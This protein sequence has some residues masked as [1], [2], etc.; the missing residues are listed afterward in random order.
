[1]NISFYNGDVN[2][3]Y[4]YINSSTISVINNHNYIDYTNKGDYFSINIYLRENDG[5]PDDLEIDDT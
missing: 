5:L 4:C 3:Y 1:M 2:G